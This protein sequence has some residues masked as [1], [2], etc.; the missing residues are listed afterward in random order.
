M[1]GLQLQISQGA[2]YYAA[3]FVIGS[4][5]YVGTG[6][7]STPPYRTVDLYEWDSQNNLWSVSG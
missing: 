7:I 4:S 2:R 3:A 6:F 1:V 5:S